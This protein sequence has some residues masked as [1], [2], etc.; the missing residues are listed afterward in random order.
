MGNNRIM[1]MNEV[2]FYRGIK[3]KYNKA[4]YGDGIYFATDTK[5]I[6]V[7][8]VSYGSVD[9]DD[10]LTEISNNPVKGSA[11]YK[12]IKDNVNNAVNNAPY[13]ATLELSASNNTYTIILRDKNGNKLSEVGP[14]IGE[15]S[16]AVDISGLRVSRVGKQHL[17][18]KSNQTA[19]LGF[20][21]DI[22]D[23]AGQSLGTSGKAYLYADENYE[24]LLEEKVIPVGEHNFDV[25]SYLEEGVL[26]NFYIKIVA[27][28]NKGE[29]SYMLWYTARL[30]NISITGSF[31]IDTV[32]KKGDKINFPGTITGVNDAKT[33]RA[34]LNGVE[35]NSVYVGGPSSSINLVVDTS[36]LSHG[37]HNVQIR[38]DYDIKDEYGTVTSTVYSNI[39]YYDVIVVE[40]G[41]NEPAFACRFD[42]ENGENLISGTPITTVSQYD[43]FNLNYYVYDS[44]QTREVSF[45][46]EGSPV[47]SNTFSDAAA[48]I[49]YR[50]TTSGYKNCYFE[51]NN[52]TY[53]FVINVVKSNYLIDEPTSSLS[54]YLDALGKSNNSS[55]R[56]NWNY[57]NVTSTFE[58]FNW[59]GNGWTGNSLKLFNG[60]KVT[61]HH[62]PFKSSASGAMAFTIRLKV[63]NVTN[64]D[65]VVVSCLDEFGY[66]LVITAQEAKLITQT[67]SIST[68]FATDETYTIGFVSFPK[69][70][71]NSSEYGVNNSNMCYV[72]VD[73]IISGGISKTAANEIYQVNPT[74]IILQANSCE[75]EV[76]AIRSYTTELTDDQMF[77]CHLIDLVNS[78]AIATEYEQND[79]LDLNGNITVEKVRGKIPYIIITGASQT[80]GL[81]QFEYAAVQNNKDDK[82]DVDSLLYVDDKDPSFNFYAVPNPDNKVGKQNP[83]IR[84][85]GTS[86][87]GY[88]RKNY[89]IYLKQGNLYLGCNEKGEGGELQS[90]A[91]YAMSSASAPVN[92]FCFKAD[93]AESSSSHNTGTTGLVEEVFRSAGDLT[94]P[95]EHVNSEKYPYQVRTTVEG[96][97]C[98]LFYRSS[99]TETPKFGG[100]FN[101][102]NDKSTEDVFGFLDIPGYHDNEEYLAEMEECAQNSL[103]FPEGFTECS[104]NDDGKTVVVT[105]EEIL[106]ELGSNPTKCW[107]FKNNTTRMGNFLEADFTKIDPDS[108]KG[109]YYWYTSW[110]SRFPD[111]DW[112]NAAFEAGVQPYYLKSTAEW[113]VSTNQSQA[114]GDL[115]PSTVT[116]NGVIY[117]YDN[118][119]YRK[120]K[121]RAELGYYFDINFLCSYYIMTDCLAAADQRVK[122][123][124]WAFWFDPSV[125]KHEIMGRMRCFPIFYDNDTILGL[126]NT[127]KIAIN[128]DADENTMNG[129]SYAFA[130]HDSTIWINL[131]ETCSDYLEAAYNRLRNENMTN[132][133]M[134]RWYNTNQSDKYSE[135]I[136]NKDSV[137]KY[138][139]PTNIGVSVLDNGKVG[140][141]K[142][143]VLSQMQGSRRSH[144]SWFINNRMDTFDA[145]Y[146]SGSYQSSEITWKGAIEVASNENIGLSASVSRNQYLG[147]VEAT[148]YKAHQLVQ[149]NEVFEFALSDGKGT[150]QGDV[151]HLYG[152]KWL[153]ELD[154]SNWGGYE[155]IYFVGKMP[156]LEK[157]IIGGHRGAAPNVEDVVLGDNTPSLKYLDI[158]NIPITNIDLASCIY[159]ETLVAS[160]SKLASVSLAEGCNIKNMYLPNTF[161]KL[162]L[163]ALPELTNNGINLENINSLIQLRI[164]K[165]NKLNGLELLNS[166][167]NS[168]GNSL[169]Y[170][171]ITD[172]NTSGN[173]QDLIKYM[174]LGLGGLDSAGNTITG[175]CKLIGTYKLTTLLDVNTY[176]ELCKYFDELEIIQP[177]YTQ[178]TFDYRV[179]TPAKLT[180]LDNNSG[181]G[182]PNKYE[183]SGHITRVLDQRHSYLVKQTSEEGIF[184]AMQL[185]DNTSYEYI[186]GGKSQLNG[187]EGDYCMYEPHYWYKG[188]NDHM[189][190]KIHLFISSE[191]ECPTESK[192]TIITT[193]DCV[194]QKGKYISTAYKVLNKAI[195]NDSNYSIY[196]YVL[197][198]THNYKQLRVCSVSLNNA[199]AIIVDVNGNV[200][201]SLSAS[202]SQGMYDTSYLFG[203]IPENAHSVYFTMSNNAITKNCLY[204][205]ESEDLEAIEPEWVEHNECFVGRL[206]S[207]NNDGLVTSAHLPAYNST[208]GQDGYYKETNMSSE[209]LCDLLKMRSVG[210]YFP[211]GY[212]T[213]K[214]IMVL[215]YLKYGTVGL[216]TEESEQGLITVGAGG[217]EGTSKYMDYSKYFADAT[218]LNYLNWGTQDTKLNSDI[219]YSSY[220]LNAAGKIQYPQI[221][222]LLGYHQLIGGGSTIST[223]DEINS[224]QSMYRQYRSG[225]E[226]R[227]LVRE[228]K[229]YTDNSAKYTKSILGGRYF[230][231]FISSAASTYV[232]TA[233]TGFC[234]LQSKN[235]SNG[236]LTIGNKIE[237]DVEAITY[238][239]QSTGNNPVTQI[240]YT[241]MQNLVRVVITPD[242]V[243]Y[244]TDSTLYKNSQ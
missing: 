56:D 194:V 11:I 229:L 208:M 193:A 24:T 108:S 219:S 76:Y 153:K 79:I 123:M 157:L 97:P 220:Q 203:R 98:L 160:G 34:Y 161:T 198:S 51:Y 156:T 206:L 109:E 31:A 25:T 191:K 46:S 10:E 244:F 128:W 63:S 68:K 113:L 222:T 55:V 95:Q 216:H 21:Y 43:L 210:Y 133:T 173:G 59:S 165:C 40:E 1:I 50:Y 137:W 67:N 93:F 138:I 15:Q 239:L 213:F 37:T 141:T 73:G 151:F 26:K 233:T 53:N 175:K 143:S 3:N 183:P 185:S 227:T 120:A 118:V 96:K 91:K 102:N 187:I 60:S 77:S 195:Q 61:V 241:V 166:I 90:N 7:N 44:K 82:Y 65:E 177:K 178:V 238:Q 114:T 205:I 20:T 231:I 149:P 89:R 9:V 134:L 132:E 103:V 192:A 100:K 215:A 81:S 182:T 86:S 188:V 130:G 72:Y 5:E 92:C 169:R 126:D 145:K 212:E 2:L 228:V 6:I 116:Y 144:R 99:T 234:G 54:L 211:M 207:T 80:E 242:K 35:V 127:G 181:Y 17:Q 107:E 240:T 78:E 171:R 225:K 150:A 196:S 110:E 84:L 33:V 201:Q 140:T 111:E 236:Y 47:S 164:E 85:Q 13:G 22:W 106:N 147:V 124:M 69:A 129:D 136:Y 139:I 48:T 74:D 199:G 148:D 16:D 186:D 38:A 49:K 122:N 28:T 117:S 237:K 224:T 168:N 226:S 14:I 94:P 209:S 184:N 23:S 142:Y 162:F 155:Y 52:K 105:K 32:T 158:T 204:L 217:S 159:L 19:L 57:N 88:P 146:K 125:E 8:G 176:N 218:N 42:Y 243:N 170:V 163:V 190:Q 200:L 152:I 87:M 66:G 4:L 174:S 101:F 83:Q 64:P 135:R 221:V 70:N 36:E 41:N 112:L 119:E 235:T 58:N 75:L 197:P 71:E 115:L 232:A 131:R 189:N 29:Q 172:I 202:V 39:I 27:N 223:D 45:Y 179:D 214:D 12:A 18:V 154:M 62:Q 121:F 180:N 167:I 104:Y 230:D 30:V